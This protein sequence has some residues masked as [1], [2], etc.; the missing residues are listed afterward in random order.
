MSSDHRD[1]S[2]IR[3]FFQLNNQTLILFFKVF[4]GFQGTN[5]STLIDGYSNLISLE[6]VVGY[7]KLKSFQD[8]QVNSNG[9][10]EKPDIT[11]PSQTLK[12]ESHEPDFG[13]IPKK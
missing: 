3:V 9:L 10:P 2:T 4:G 5:L 7:W 11:Y 8:N 1:G 6:I 13:I 12:K